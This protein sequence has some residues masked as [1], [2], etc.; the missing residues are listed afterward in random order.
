MKIIAGSKKFRIHHERIFSIPQISEKVSHSTGF[1]FGICQCIQVHIQ[2]ALHIR[3]GV[4]C[5]KFLSDENL[6]PRCCLAC[7]K[8]T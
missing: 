6:S 2:N 4:A 5:L 1:G 7:I 3:S 8:P